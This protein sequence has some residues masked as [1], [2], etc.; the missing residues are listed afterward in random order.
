MSALWCGCDPEASYTC[1]R[2]REESQFINQHVADRVQDRLILDE[3]APVDE[4]TID[5]IERRIGL[6]P[7]LR[8]HGTCARQV[9]SG[10]CDCGLTQALIAAQQAREDIASIYA[11]DPT[12]KYLVLVP[13]DFHIETLVKGLVGL[14]AER[15]VAI[16]TPGA[17]D[18]QIYDLQTGAL[19]APLAPVPPKAL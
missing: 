6:A 1:D 14:V 15:S 17:A 7:W 9:V 11:L 4:R 10:L 5:I 2:H 8:H 19:V 12:T 16:S 13:P 3:T 18:V